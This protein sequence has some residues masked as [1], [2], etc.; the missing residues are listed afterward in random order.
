ML[1]YILRPTKSS[2]LCRINIFCECLNHK[3]Y[4][5][6]LLLYDVIIIHSMWFLNQR[7]HCILRWTGSKKHSDL[8]C[9]PSFFLISYLPCLLAFFC[10]SS[11]NK[12]PLRVFYSDD[13]SLNKIL[14][15]ILE[16]LSTKNISKRIQWSRLTV[17]SRLAIFSDRQLRCCNEISFILMLN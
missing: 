13:L 8:V 10:F 16:E 5:S 12:A 14:F 9:R 2:C 3:K 6:S 15:R 11:I 4:E 7:L 1:F 17:A